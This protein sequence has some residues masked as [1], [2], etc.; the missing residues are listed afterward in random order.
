MR[1]PMLLAV[2]AGA[3][4]A[5]IFGLVSFIGWV[6]NQIN[7][8]QK[9]PQP[10]RKR[11]PRD[12]TIQDEIDQFLSEREGKPRSPRRRDDEIL[13]PD[14]VELIDEPPRR[15]APP[16]PVQQKP[17]PKPKPSSP[18]PP[19]QRPQPQRPRLQPVEQSTTQVTHPAAAA[20]QLGKD[21]QQHVRQAMAPRLSAAVGKDL[22]HAIDQ[23]VT[24]HLG[25]F[26][27]AGTQ[28]ANVGS[29][30]GSHARAAA[31]RQV[32]E[33][34]GMLRNPNSMRAV[35]IANEI[36]SKPLAQRQK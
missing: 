12:R 6:M 28:S 22:P 24:R 15:P 21:L 26:S 1:L 32:A 33:I 9:P 36:L 30:A 11:A 8:A 20:A 14:Q 3:I 17:R 23:E 4:V 25:T 19:S 35:I 18:K 34:I 16:K 5:V 10:P 27:G 7:G 2:D 13:T 31:D 29:K